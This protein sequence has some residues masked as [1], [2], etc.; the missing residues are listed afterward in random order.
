MLHNNHF[1]KPIVTCSYM[2]VRFV[3]Q[4]YSASQLLEYVIYSVENRLTL[5]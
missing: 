4:R 1:I 2:H 3:L 5:N